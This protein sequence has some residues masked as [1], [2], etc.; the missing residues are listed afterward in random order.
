MRSILIILWLLLSLNGVRAADTLIWQLGKA[1]DSARDFRI[2]YRAWE[3]GSAPAIQNSPAMDHRTHTFQYVIGENREI[4][5][6]DMVCG[7]TTM[8]ERVFMLDDEMVNRVRLQW[9]EAAAGNRKFVFNAVDWGNRCGT[10][11]G[12]EVLLP[13]GRKCLFSLPE[14]DF[15]TNGAKLYS[16]IFPVA[17]GANELTLG[18]TTMAKHHA[19]NFD[20]LALY[21]TEESPALPPVLEPRFDAFANIYHPGQPVVM[22]LTVHNLPEGNHQAAFTVRDVF[23]E[24]VAEGTAGL[25]EGHA[26]IALLSSQPGHFTVHCKV[27]EGSTE[28]TY[29][30]TEP[31]TAEYIDDSRFGCHAFHGDGYRPRYWPERQEIKMHRAFLAGAKWAR[32]HRP[33]WSIMEETK[34]Q[35][36]W[37]M[38]D[39]KLL[40]AEKYKIRPLLNITAVPIWASPSDDTKLTVCGDQRRLMYPPTRDW[41]AWPDFITA[42]VQRYRGRVT[43]L[44]IGNE[45]GYT[46]AFWCNGSA[47]DFG[48]YLQLAYQAAKRANPDTVILPGAPLDTTFFEDALRSIGNPRCFDVMSVHYQGNG[49]RGSEKS[50]GWFALLA[51]LGHQ[52]PLVN[53]E[54]MQWRGEPDPL[55]RASSMVKTFV[56]DASQGIVRTYAFQIFADSSTRDYSSFDDF[57]RPLPAFTAYR[58]MTHRLE[59]TKFVADLSG[60]EHEAYLFERNGEPIVVFWRDT[61]GTVE[62]PVGTASATLVNLVDVASPATI[63]QSRAIL[64]ATPTVQYLEGGDLALLALYGKTLAALPGEI[65]VSPGRTTTIKTILPART[66]VTALV[67]PDAITGE[68]AAGSIAVT[69]AEQTPEGVYDAVFQVDLDGH[70]IT[71]PCLVEVSRGGIGANLIPN[72]DFEHGQEEWFPSDKPEQ[73]QI[74][75]D[76]GIEGS[77]GLRIHGTIFFGC[78]GSLKVRQGE[79]YAVFYDLKGNGTLGVVHTVKDVD[80]NTL[81]PPKPCITALS[82]RATADWARHSD[83]IVINQ[84]GADSLKIALLANYQR[85]DDELT[86]DNISLV[87]LSN[88]LTVSK[89]TNSSFFSRLAKDAAVAI[90]G[91]LDEWQHVRWMTATASTQIVQSPGVDYAGPGDLSADCAIMLD[92]QNFYAAFRVR[93]DHVLP[94]RDDLRDA[95][96]DDSVQ[97]GI[98]PYNAGEDF[99]QLLV[100]RLADGSVR[101]FKHR[102]FWTPELPENITRQGVIESAEVATAIVPDG[103]VY[104]I[105]IPLR[106]LYPLD[107]STE[108]FAFSWLIN[109]NDG[110]GRKYIEWSSGIG[111]LQT[112]SMFGLLRCTE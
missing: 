37:D 55:T 41:E 111:G 33:Q 36:H 107:T 10:A 63:D 40:L 90:D 20:Y 59:R 32:Y 64:T 86:V 34:G 74:Q 110:N 23:G 71:A 24:T 43:H 3:Y 35:Y 25:H 58:T 83:L 38:L 48:K 12:I 5:S 46:S 82:V 108:R 29:A 73:W 92:E 94:A 13:G 27:G 61:P 99:T 47:P 72:G 84:P 68:P 112:S 87:R 77:C 1:D 102:N 28:T 78:T 6:P 88:T 65:L 62:L 91:K 105:R 11:E 2:W 44:E 106:E 30:V 76:I 109:D 52:V 67:L 89:A 79:R 8:Y 103:I 45:P 31:V 42:L 16:V 66:A 93:D 50:L 81:F 4:A 56:R 53:S 100:A 17:A 70:A 101:V 18:I 95:W 21:D 75:P 69:A 7:I 39:R 96:R 9:Q 60:P 85:P 19:F 97:F 51:K 15:R 98:D 57:D 26:D 14:G 80:G 104:E 49:R 22:R 54:E